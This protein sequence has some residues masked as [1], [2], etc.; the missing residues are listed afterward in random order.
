VINA[1]Y[2]QY[3]VLKDVSDELNFVLSYEEEEDWDIYWIDGP[4]TPTFLL[5]M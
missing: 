2:T 1:I 3:E 4:I 5:K